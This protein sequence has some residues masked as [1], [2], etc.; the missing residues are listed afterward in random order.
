MSMNGRSH[1]LVRPQGKGTRRIGVRPLAPHPALDAQVDDGR[2]LVRRA[3]RGVGDP[4]DLVGGGRILFLDLAPQVGGDDEIP[5]AL[6][7]QD[8]ALEFELV[9]ELDDL[10]VDREVDG[11]LAL[12][13]EAVAQALLGPGAFESVAASVYP[14][15]P[16]GWKA[17]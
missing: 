16:E 5:E 8:L 11:Q 17:T 14:T 12:L 9:A 1:E 2:H 15:G 4:V 3:Q 7:Q 6:L 10:A 13:G